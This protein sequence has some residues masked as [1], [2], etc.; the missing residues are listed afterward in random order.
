MREFEVS[1][2]SFSNRTESFL[3]NEFTKYRLPPYCQWIDISGLQPG[4]YIVRLD[5]NPSH[6]VS[7]TNFLDNDIICNLHY[8]IGRVQATNCH[9]PDD[10][11]IEHLDQNFQEEVYDD[12]GGP[13]SEISFG[14]PEMGRK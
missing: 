14:P 11:A 5:T 13:N 8:Q 6:F 3:I 10:Y 1:R 4:N 2:S 9:I 7:E 12:W